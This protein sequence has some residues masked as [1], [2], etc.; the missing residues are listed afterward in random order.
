MVWSR[1]RKCSSCRQSYLDHDKRTKKCKRGKGSFTSSYSC[2]CNSSYDRHCTMVQTQQEREA[3]G[4]ATGTPW[5][6][7]AETW[8]ELRNCRALKVLGCFGLDLPYVPWFFLICFLMF[9]WKCLVS[10]EANAGLPTAHMGGVGGFTS[11]ADGID[12]ALAGQFIQQ[13]YSCICTIHN[14]AD[15]NYDTFVPWFWKALGFSQHLFASF[16][17]WP[18]STESQVWSP[19]LSLNE[20]TARWR[21]PMV[22]LASRN[23]L[24][25]CHHL[26]LRPMNGHGKPHGP[27]KTSW[28]VGRVPKLQGMKL[29][30]ID[31]MIEQMKHP[32]RPCFVNVDC[33]MVM[34]CQRGSIFRE[35]TSGNARLWVW[36]KCHRNADICNYAIK[37]ILDQNSF[38]PCMLHDQLWCKSQ[39][40]RCKFWDT[41]SDI[42]EVG[43]C[44][45]ALVEVLT[46]V[47]YIVELWCHKVSFQ[48]NCRGKCF[49]HSWY[50]EDIIQDTSRISGKSWDR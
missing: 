35:R 18:T 8:T 11:L 7:S 26:G 45:A 33:E 19:V 34:I 6:Q 37:E 2:S 39:L 36:C 23:L 50:R 48:M 31:E 27:G 41:L 3:S 20:S 1:I 47:L 32:K 13:K 5:M 22:S 24:L 42:H 44:L 29:N 28:P 16:Y 25:H 4:K 30:E 46:S 40:V 12:R 38:G 17:F 49:E 9:F 43:R 21:N 15:T 10:P 14:L